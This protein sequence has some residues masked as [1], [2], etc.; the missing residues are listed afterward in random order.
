MLRDS[1][2]EASLI[3]VDASDWLLRLAPLCLQLID[4]AVGLQNNKVSEL[5]RVNP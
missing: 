1:Q 4:Y 3:I 2:L 5:N